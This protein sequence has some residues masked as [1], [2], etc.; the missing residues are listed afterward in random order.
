M[1]LPEGVL[2]YAVLT[3]A[4]LPKAQEREQCTP[5][6]VYIS[7]LVINIRLLC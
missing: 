6:A 4:N 3:C 5:K 7:I 2:A 1:V